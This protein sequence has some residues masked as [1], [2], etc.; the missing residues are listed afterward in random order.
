MNQNMYETAPFRVSAKSLIVDLLSTIP[1]GYSVTVGALL[2]AGALFEIGDNSMRV[3]LARLR[4]RGTVAS[5]GRGVYRLSGTARPVNREVNAWATVESRLGDWDGS[6]IAID[7]S[8]IS[9]RDQRG[10][11]TRDRACRLLGFEALS[12]ALRLRPN[13]WRGGVEDVRRRLAGLGFEPPAAV[14]QLSALDD[15]T[16]AR[17]RGLWNRAELDVGY[18]ATRNRLVAATERLPILSSEQAMIE[19]FCIGGQAVRQIVLDPLLP[20]SLVDGEARRAMIEAMRAYDVLGKQAW[21]QWAGESI[22]LE[23]SPVD[24]GGWGRSASA[25]DVV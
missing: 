17:A 13:N 25:T 23:S 7:T 14:F 11:R 16:C 18:R 22:E 9:R 21:K 8:P 10:N 19:S 12:P 3:S 15:E 1:S 24:R 4:S 5:D 20:E 2:R 6:W